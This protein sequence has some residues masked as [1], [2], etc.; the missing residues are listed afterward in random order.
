MEKSVDPDQL[1][2]LEASW[3]EYAL[4]SKMQY[5]WVLQNKY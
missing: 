1:D 4:Y 5:I 3:S 2:S